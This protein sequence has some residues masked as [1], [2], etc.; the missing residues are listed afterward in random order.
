MSGSK[1]G[2]SKIS[3]HLK[4]VEESPTKPV[5]EKQKTKSPKKKPTDEFIIL[6]P[7]ATTGATK[8]DELSKSQSSSD[9]SPSLS[10]SMV[11][12]PHVTRK[13]VVIR[14]IL[15]PLSPSLKKRK[16]E[17]IAKHISKKQKK[18]LRKLVINDD[19]IEDEVLQDPPVTTSQFGTSNVKMI[20]VSSSVSQPEPI[21]IS[22]PLE[23]SWS[24]EPLE[25]FN[26]IL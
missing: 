26:L 23:T 14:E 15:V 20:V 4:K 1:K 12:K 6:K 10:P 17:D 24:Q 2:P 3:R 22:L 9:R 18:K 5:Q 25:I 8:T 21:T 16:F 13:S 11:R 19:S 7:K